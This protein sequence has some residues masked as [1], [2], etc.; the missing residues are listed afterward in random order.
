MHADRYNADT[1]LVEAQLDEACRRI[2]EPQL[3][4][5]VFAQRSC[6]NFSAVARPD[7]P[8]MQLC[9]IAE[10]VHAVEPI[11]SSSAPNCLLRSSLLVHPHRG[12]AA[13]CNCWRL[14]RRRALWEDAEAAPKDCE[15]SMRGCRSGPHQPCVSCAYGMRCCRIFKGI[16]AAT[17]SA[18]NN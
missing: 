12:R 1:Q 3:V 6:E 10:V 13:K 9:L 15:A 18:E 11:L 4:N 16:D 5:E 2:H 14:T 8:Q 7:K 17:S